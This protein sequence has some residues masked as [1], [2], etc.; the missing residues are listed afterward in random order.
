MRRRREEEEGDEEKRRKRRRRRRKRTMYTQP[1][2]LQARRCKGNLV[3]S[4]EPAPLL[5]KSV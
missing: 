1:Y 4:M 2:I 3:T 5:K